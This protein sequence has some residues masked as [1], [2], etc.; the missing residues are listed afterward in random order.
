MSAKK[1]AIPSAAP[2]GMEAAVDMHF[3]QCDLYTI[4]E[5]DESGVRSVGTVEKVPHAQGGCLAPVQLLASRGVDTLLAA[6]M[7]M[8]P[9]TGF[10]QEG[11]KVYHTEEQETVGQAVQAFL[12]GTLKPFDTQRTCGGCH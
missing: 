3:G 10:H 6:G 8:R 9:L 11:I 12:Q 4:V 1:V 5:L 7:G 2:G